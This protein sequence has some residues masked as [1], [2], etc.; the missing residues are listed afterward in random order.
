MH[1]PC[2]DKQCWPNLSDTF[3]W[4]GIIASY[5]Y[6]MAFYV[7]ADEPTIGAREA[8]RRSKEM[9]QGNK[10]KL[11]CLYWHFFGW[12]ILCILTLGIGFLWLGPYMS[13]STARFY[14]DVR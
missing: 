3:S 8:L 4:A 14:E 13:A 11:F 2:L 7:V 10:F 9:M 12:A 5:A 1:A 6:A